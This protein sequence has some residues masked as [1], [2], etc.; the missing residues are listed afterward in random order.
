M[1]FQTMLHKYVNMMRKQRF[2]DFAAT[3]SDYRETVQI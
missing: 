2:Q 3:T 1:L